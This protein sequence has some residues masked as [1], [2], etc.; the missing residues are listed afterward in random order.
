MHKIDQ[1]TEALLSSRVTTS[2]E[3]VWLA[4]QN[5]DDE[6]FDL[7]YGRYSDNL[8]SYL[9]ILLST[10]SELGQLD[11]VF[12][13]T[14]L[15]VFKERKRFTVS[16]T[17]SFVGWI[18]RISHNLAYSALRRSRNTVSIDDEQFEH[19]YVTALIV[20]PDFGGGEQL[21]LDELMAKVLQTVEHLPLMLREVFVMSEFEK[22]TLESIAEALGIS[23]TNAKVRLFRARRTIRA[24]LTKV[25]DVKI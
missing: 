15:T 16:K 6:S 14:W 4:F 11:D 1:K 8:Y 21:T 7:L 3:D 12:Q 20:E 5:G 23:K 25:L 19:E 22:M 17:G 10:T 13:E 24:K 9:K 2:D 18:F